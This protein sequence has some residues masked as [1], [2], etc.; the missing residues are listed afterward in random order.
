MDGLSTIGV[1]QYF[2]FPISDGLVVRFWFF[3]FGNLSEL[4]FPFPL[5]FGSFF[6]FFK[7][8]KCLDALH[9]EKLSKLRK[10]WKIT[11]L[12]ELC[13][14]EKPN[15]VKSIHHYSQSKHE[16]SPHKL[17]C[18]QPGFLDFF[19]SQNHWMTPKKFWRSLFFGLDNGRLTS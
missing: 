18:L 4:I 11:C 7:V 17:Y 19:L 5:N 1:H 14:T 13:R 9:L 8:S 2:S 10:N 3:G 16:I 12:M 6:W 15:L